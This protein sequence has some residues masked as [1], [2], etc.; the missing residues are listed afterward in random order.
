MPPGLRRRPTREL[1]FAAATPK[2]ALR[3]LETTS[4]PSERARLVCTVGLPLA[5]DH[6]ELQTASRRRS[7][8]SQTCNGREAFVS[9]G[10]RP[11]G[12]LHHRG[13]QRALPS[14]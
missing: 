9:G 13:L 11:T 10:R 5:L 4:A 2:L 7:T 12:G 3:I 14:T 1:A 8:D 6:K